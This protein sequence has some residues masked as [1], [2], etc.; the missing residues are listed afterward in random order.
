MVCP[1][2][3]TQDRVRLTIILVR[4]TIILVINKTS[5]DMDCPADSSETIVVDITIL[6]LN[7][8]AKREN[9]RK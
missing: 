4:S 3:I 6:R 1:P 9:G 8:P 2:I 5:V 7:S